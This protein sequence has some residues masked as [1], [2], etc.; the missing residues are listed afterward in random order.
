MGGFVLSFLKDYLCNRKQFVRCDG[1]RS[2]PLQLSSGVPQGSIL[3]SLL[4][5][6]FINNLPTSLISST[7]YLY[8]DEAKFLFID[9]SNQEIQKEVDR[10]SLWVPRSRMSLAAEK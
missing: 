4:F 3:G 9:K 2:V 8:A 6:I 5:C 7:P 10:I 1:V